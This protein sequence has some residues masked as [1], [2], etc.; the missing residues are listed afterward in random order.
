MD[1]IE[2]KALY[3]SKK[4]IVNNLA[5]EDDI[6]EISIIKSNVHLTKP[7]KTEFWISRQNEV[8][9]F[10]NDCCKILLH[11]NINLV[12]NVGLHDIYHNN[13][14]IMVFST[15]NSKQQNILIPDYYSMLDYNGKLDTKDNMSF[16][17]K[18][19]KAIFVGSSTG[20]VNPRVNERLN[21]CDNFKNNNNIKCYISNFCQINMSDIHY[22]YPNYRLFSSL[23][24]PISKQLEYKYIINVDGNTCTLDRIPWI[25]NSNS[26]CLKKKST[27]KCW[28]Y[29]FMN[30]NEHF[31]EFDND[32]EIEK[33]INT[34][35]LNDCK[36]IIKNANE[37]CNNYLKKNCHL[38]YMSKLLY[39]ISK[40]VG[41]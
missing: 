26:L 3:E 8:V 12:I 2:K 25:F 11:R 39:F 34:I 18:L 33:I 32:D 15:P 20:S 6:I 36:R 7:T 31:V 5:N 17:S 21:L 30:K 14:G 1:N 38:Q 19:N 23:H 24:I 40:N 9:K 22:E 28:Y 35:S 13:L 41:N 29:D 4:K 10:L 37:F 16:E 27:H